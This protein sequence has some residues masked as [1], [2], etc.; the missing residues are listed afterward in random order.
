M[1]SQKDSGYPYTFDIFV[2]LNA[3]PIRRKTLLGLEPY[4]RIASGDFLKVCPT[5]LDGDLL[6]S[7]LKIRVSWLDPIVLG[8]L[9]FTTPNEPL[10]WETYKYLFNGNIL[11]NKM[12]L[13]ALSN[14][15]IRFEKFWMEIF[16]TENMIDE[17]SLAHANVWKSVMKNFT[18]FNKRNNRTSA[19]LL[20]RLAITYISYTRYTK[21]QFIFPYYTPDTFSRLRFVGCGR[22]GMSAIPFQELTNV[23]DKLTWLCIFLSI[24]AQLTIAHYLRNH[25]N[26]VDRVTTVLKIF[27]EQ[28]NPLR[29]SVANTKHFR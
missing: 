24:L 20:R 23:F 17:V 3:A 13:H 19:T 29:N 28:E 26:L 27:L 14:G 22:Q 1:A 9:V 11:V 25:G 10:V 4:S 15:S 8:K 18:F 5:C 12:I 16:S 7:V 6:G 21:T 2:I